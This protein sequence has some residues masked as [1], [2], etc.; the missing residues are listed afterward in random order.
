MAWDILKRAK[1]SSVSPNVAAPGV[2]Y[3]DS[4]WASGHG[5]GGGYGWGAGPREFVG[6]SRGPDTRTEIGR[7]GDFVEGK[8]SWERNPQ[9]LGFPHASRWPGYPTR[10]EPPFYESGG[11]SGGGGYGSGSGG[12]NFMGGTMLHSRC[13]VVFTCTDLISR[14]M[15]SMNLRR[16]KDSSPLPSLPWMD[17][18]EPLIYASMVDAVKSIVNS[19]LYRGE[20][21]LL[22]TARYEN[23]QIARWVALN[24]D[25][26]TFKLSPVDGLPDWFVDGRPVPRGELLHIR[27]ETWPGTVR[28]VGPLEAAWRSIASATAMEAWGT[29]LAMTNG[30]P[31]AVLQSQAKLTKDQ[32]NELKQSWYEAAISRG[33]LPAILSGGLTYEPLNL[34]PEDIGLLDMRSFDEQRIASC[35]GVPLWLVGLPMNAGLTYS[36][37]QATFDYF[38][39]AT[40]RSM[41]YNISSALSAWAL[42]RGEWM[43][44]D[45]ESLVQPD[46]PQRAKAYDSLIKSGVLRPEEVRT[47]EN[48]APV[49]TPTEDAVL[50]QT[51]DGGM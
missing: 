18:P 9:D 5:P 21:F 24:P 42:V 37:A 29:Q 10:W 41:A 36:T 51:M 16:T 49:P 11:G 1:G 12:G 4:G 17:N 14:T 8:H 7:P 40:L 39:R 33:T 3:T 25:T 15:S 20:A 44:F 27:Y 43:H 30:I 19:L 46:L 13:A 28:G 26:M 22:V 45:N 6:S 35:F 38:W 31:T 34:K 32:A 48:L 50:A 47:F 2:V 23:G